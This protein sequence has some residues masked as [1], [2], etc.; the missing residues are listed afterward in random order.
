MVLRSAT[1]A[2]RVCGVFLSMVAGAEARAATVSGAAPV[3][4]GGT[5]FEAELAAESARLAATRGKPEGIG[6]LL[7][8]AA[9]YEEVPPGL[10]ERVLRETADA[11]GTDPLV[12]A[13][14]AH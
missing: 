5:L 2:V 9:L 13:Q 8:V 11:K 12:A 14:A 7:A 1:L 3:S 6:S 4:P 10:V